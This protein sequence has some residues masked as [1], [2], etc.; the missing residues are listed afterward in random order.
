GQQKAMPVIGWFS[1]NAAE[2]G[3][4][5]LAG[6]LEGLREAGLVEG[7]DIAVEYRW[8]EGANDRLRAMAAD[9]VGRKVDLIVASGGPVPAT[10]AIP[11][12]FANGSDAVAD[13]LVSS[14]ARPVGNITGISFL[15]LELSAKRL[16]LLA[17]LVPQAP[18]MGLLTNPANP[19]AERNIASVHEAAHA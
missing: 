4:T 6:F 13:G 17:E 14:L 9:L 1:S 8:A 10:S 16:E 12:V 2:P 5:G 7:R 18:V 19:N 3:A 11:I 15:V